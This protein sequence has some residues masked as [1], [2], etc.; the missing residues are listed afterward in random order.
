MFY[1]NNKV[2]QPCGGA[3]FPLSLPLVG[4]CTGPPQSALWTGPRFSY[5]GFNRP[6][7]LVLPKTNNILANE[8]PCF[9][10]DPG[11]EFKGKGSRRPQGTHERF[12]NNNNKKNDDDS[13][14]YV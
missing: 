13:N 12:S 4:A 3:S 11:W 8:C 6:F 5:E 2:L 10:K 1:G 7:L 14:V 9:I